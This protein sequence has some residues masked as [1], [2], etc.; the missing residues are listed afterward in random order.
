MNTGMKSVVEEKEVVEELNILSNQLTTLAD[1]VGQ[2]LASIEPVLVSGT[3]SVSSET[4]IQELCPLASQVREY[5]FNVEGI[6][7]RVQDAYNRVQI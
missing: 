3:P 7:D 1:V 6:R 2:L 4:P 5:R